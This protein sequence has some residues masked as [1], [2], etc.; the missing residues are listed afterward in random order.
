MARGAAR[1]GVFEAA[2]LYLHGPQQWLEEYLV[3]WWLAV[4]GIARAVSFSLDLSFSLSDS[5]THTCS[6]THSLSISLSRSL[7]V[8]A[9]TH[10]CVCVCVCECNKDNGTAVCGGRK[11]TPNKWKLKPLHPT[12]KCQL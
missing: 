8:C 11:H 6:L 12:K 10:T 7:S 5:H 4:A 1:G 3:L 2:A 9:Y